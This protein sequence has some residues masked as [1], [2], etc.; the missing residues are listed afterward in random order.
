MN[1]SGSSGPS[2]FRLYRSARGGG[3]ANTLEGMLPHRFTHTSHYSKHRRTDGQTAKH[4]GWQTSKWTDWQMNTWTDRQT[5]KLISDRWTD[6]W[7]DVLTQVFLS[8]DSAI[9]VFIHLIEILS[10]NKVPHVREIRWMQ[11]N[12]HLF[13]VQLSITILISQSKFPSVTL[14]LLPVGYLASFVVELINSVGLC[15]GKWVHSAQ[16]MLQMPPHNHQLIL[17]EQLCIQYNQC[18]FSYVCIHLWGISAFSWNH[19]FLSP[20]SRHT[21]IT[22]VTQPG[23]LRQ[24]GNLMMAH[25]CRE[26]IIMHVQK[27]Q[28]RR[29]TVVL[30]FINSLSL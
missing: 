3:A 13:S 28:R 24:H 17:K 2:L 7:S 5:D 27:W 4:I 6:S 9:F 14:N 25:S 21:Y 29:I 11:I 22:S 20:H 12:W 23:H 15:R 19:C 26:L 10:H 1:H 8:W 16:H 30:L 18:F